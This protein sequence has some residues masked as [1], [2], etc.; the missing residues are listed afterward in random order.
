[1][2]QMMINTLSGK[3]I[4]PYAP[5]AEDIDIRD[6]AHALSMQC[7]FN[8]H[9][10]RFYSVAE[11]SVLVSDLL[12]DN[13]K[14]AGLLHDAAEAYLGDVI[15]PIKVNMAN[16]LDLEAQMEAVIFESFGLNPDLIKDI[17][18]ADQ[19]A[20][21]LEKDWIK[22]RG[23]SDHLGLRGLP[24]SAAYTLFINSFN[25]LYQGQPHLKVAA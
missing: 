20:L 12:P 7:R 6:I 8:G 5:K 11:H 13:L 19:Y 15:S 16:Y 10:P 22:N 9:V 3:E 25:S 4:N 1:M 24:H 17:K 2:T 14:L 21:S 18:Y 23:I